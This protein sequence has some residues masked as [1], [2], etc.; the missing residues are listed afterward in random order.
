VPDYAPDDELIDK[1]LAVLDGIPV[2]FPFGRSTFVKA[3]VA[4]GP[5]PKRGQGHF[6]DWLIKLYVSN[7]PVKIGH[8]PPS[9]VRDRIKNIDTTAAKLLLLLLGINKKNADEVLES[10]RRCE[11]PAS[12]RWRAV[13]SAT[14]D[15]L[16]GVARLHLPTAGTAITDEYLQAWSR[17]HP[18]QLLPIP[19]FSRLNDCIFDLLWLQRQAETAAG[20]V[21]KRISAGRGGARARPTREGKLIRE[22]IGVY[23][24]MRRQYPKSGPMPGYGGPLLR[25]I[26][27]VADLCWTH[28]DADLWRT[29]ITDAQIRDVWESN[30]KI[31]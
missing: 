1:A 18:G 27:A 28:A 24:A 14:G 20:E 7:Q 19:G 15:M 25:F 29:K 17:A 31:L 3:M 4:F 13:A 30:R 9:K 5:L 2:R 23:V 11:E 22:T 12:D 8:I 16:A 21:S 10:L 6:I 26:H